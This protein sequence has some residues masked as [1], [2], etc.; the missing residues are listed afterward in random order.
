MATAPLKPRKTVLRWIATAA[1][2][3]V[4]FLGVHT[5][6]FALDQVIDQAA[7][8]KLV[9]QIK[10]LQ[11]QLTE[12]QKANGLLNDQ[13]NAIGR[14]G[15]ISVP[16][17]NL[18]RLASRLRQDAQCLA[19]DLQK[20]M[21]DVEYDDATWGSIC[22]AGDAYRKTLWLDPDKIAKKPWED[23][24]AARNAVEK[25]RQN[26]AVDVASKAIGQGDIDVK[27]A[28]RLGQSA[29]ELDAAAKA[30]VS[31]NERLAVIAQGSVL[32]AR[33][34]ALQTQILAQLLKVQS[35]WFAL[36]A[37]PPGSTLAKEDDK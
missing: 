31:D 21:P 27:E 20:L 12:L 26:M 36:T 3:S 17:V 1:F 37:L 4:A 22:S 10:K 9:D 2:A 30:A 5:S 18:D 33:S 15:Q 24:V 11:D 19:P 6:A 23:R 28:D 34:A 8:A 25:R 7:I 13:L 29:D 14:A 16:M 35:T 32:H